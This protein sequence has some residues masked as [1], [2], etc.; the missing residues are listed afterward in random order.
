MPTMNFLQIK[1]SFEQLLAARMELLEIQ[2]TPYA[3]GSGF[4]AYRLQGRNLLLIYNGKDD[5]V[6][7]LA[8]K[9]HEPYPSKS[10]TKL[11]EGSVAGLLSNGKKTIEEF[12]ITN[13]NNRRQNNGG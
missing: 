8:S 6:E 5:F 9:P 2:Y 13:N 10:W 11:Y 1:D 12:I 4:C 3:F 7:L